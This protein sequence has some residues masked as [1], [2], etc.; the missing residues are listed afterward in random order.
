MCTQSNK[1]AIFSIMYLKYIDIFLVFGNT[2]SSV[3]PEVALHVCF[4]INIQHLIKLIIS[5]YCF[6]DSMKNQI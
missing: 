2:R 1:I 5:A 3:I 4:N 6:G